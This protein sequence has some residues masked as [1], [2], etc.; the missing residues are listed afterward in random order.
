M[1]LC[2][3]DKGKEEGRIKMAF[4]FVTYRPELQAC[5]C[6]VVVS[7]SYYCLTRLRIF[8]ELFEL[9]V[10]SLDQRRKSERAPRTAVKLSC[11][12]FSKM[13]ITS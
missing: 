5:V 3:D 12:A 9:R 6:C 4:S 10:N 13:S 11:L 8:E 7:Q 2:G 1:S